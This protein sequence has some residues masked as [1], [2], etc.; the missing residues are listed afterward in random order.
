MIFASKL[1]NLRKKAGFSQE[2]LAEKLGVS[3]QAV[4]KW[5]TENGVPEIENIISISRLF[6]ISID[7]LLLDGE[8]KKED[9]EY[10]FESLVEYDIDDVKC[11]DV[12]LGEAKSVFVNGHDG[13]KLYVRLASNTLSN[14]EENLKVKIDDIKKRIDVEVTKFGDITKSQLKEDLTVILGLPNRYLKCL[15]ISTNAR[16][17]ELNS[18][19]AED[20]ELDVK[21]NNVDIKNIKGNIE[22]D[23]NQDMKIVCDS[24]DGELAINQ[25]SATSTLFVPEKLAFR[26]RKKGIGCKVYYEKAGNRVD[27][28]SQDSSENVIELNGIKSELII[29]LLSV[30]GK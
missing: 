29:S 26:S 13:E 14:V 28:F 11:F 24:L 8:V 1:K 20:I 12:K 2:K 21:L 17:I 30:E 22:I 18:L 25:V 23:C 15:E 19:Q 9:L 10:L 7:E 3:R 16:D 5:E 6:D 4:T 27:D